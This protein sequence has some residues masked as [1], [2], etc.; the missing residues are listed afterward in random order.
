MS[1]R[2]LSSDRYYS[3][4]QIL[5]SGMEQP[6][7][8]ARSFVYGS[9]PRLRVRKPSNPQSTFKPTLENKMRSLRSLIVAAA[10]GVCGFGLASSSA[11]A[12]AAGPSNA[13][14]WTMQSI[15]ELRDEARAQAG[16]HKSRWECQPAGPCT[17]VQGYWGPPPVAGAWALCLRSPVWGRG[18]ERLLPAAA[19]L[20]GTDPSARKSGRRA[21]HFTGSVATPPSVAAVARLSS[22]RFSSRR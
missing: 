4:G 20:I 11:S 21:F 22:W 13:L 16:W 6:S 7:L 19:E 2:G 12:Q 3:A 10:L 9:V 8:V 1:A 15:E 14:D 5:A 18:L 17:W